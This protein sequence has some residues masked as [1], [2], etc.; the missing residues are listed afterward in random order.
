M[1]NV[2]S[3]IVTLQRVL[4]QGSDVAFISTTTPMSTSRHRD[5]PPAVQIGGYL[6][7]MARG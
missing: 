5:Q 2:R 4:P 1:Y 6:G 3:V 7:L